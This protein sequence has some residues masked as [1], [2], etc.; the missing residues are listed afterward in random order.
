MIP[1]YS[2]LWFTVHCSFHGF[3]IHIVL[4]GFERLDI[5]DLIFT[6]GS[7]ISY[8]YIRTDLSFFFF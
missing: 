3:I 2:R 4:L 5:R 6:I 1:F 7:N 8:A